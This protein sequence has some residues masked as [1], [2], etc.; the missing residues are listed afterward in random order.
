[1]YT[2]TV[3]YSYCAQ[4]TFV[5][6]EWLAGA[7]GAA[8]AVYNDYLWQ[9]E[10][11]YRKEQPKVVPLDRYG[12]LPSNYAWMRKYPQKIAEQA[13]RQAESAYN[14][15]FKGLAGQRRNRPGKPHFKR[16]RSGGSITWN[17]V[18]SLKL[19][20]LNRKWAAVRI[21]KQGSWLKFRLTRE[22]PSEPTGVTLKLSPSGEYT[23]SFTVQQQLSEPK[24]EGPV[25]GIDLGLT[26]L[27][28]V[29]KEDGSRYKV[30]APKHY[31][32]AERKLARLNREHSRKQKGS[33][34]RERARLALAKQHAHVAAQRL[35]QS[36][37]IAYRLASENQA[38]SL[39]ALNLKGLVRAKLSKSFMDAGLGQLAA[40]VEQA[41]KRL[42][43]RVERV[44]PAYTSQACAV[45]G[46][47]DGPKSLSIREWQ[48]DCGAR[49]DRDYNAALNVLLLAGGHSERLN[50]P[51]GRVSREE[52]AKPA[53]LAV[54]TEGTTS[55]KAYRP[56]RRRTRAKSQARRVSLKAQASI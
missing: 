23:V 35:D 40:C 14:E 36:R 51:G 11:V 45:C 21:P 17:G 24:L 25:A 15:F 12:M 30:A 13:R 49:L 6:Q 41:A 27:A 38:V 52:L 9:K 26:D 42:G 29:V 2:Q 55:Y 8:R 3:K 5:Q 10:R 46:T 54:S 16:K 48:C 34:N 50:G 7:F 19:K 47:I 37:K 28:A 32:R 43:T 56:R 39:E 22:L 44:N 20:R 53:D 33:K 31:R 18:G 1:M 4:P